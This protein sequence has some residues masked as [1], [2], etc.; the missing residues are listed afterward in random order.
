M[1]P[2]AGKKLKRVAKAS[3]LSGYLGNILG[4]STLVL[5]LPLGYAMRNVW[6]P[7]KPGQPNIIYILA[8]DL[9]YGD[10]SCYQPEGKIHTPH[11][12]RLADQGIRFT[13][14]HSPSGVC[15]PTRYGILTGEYPWRSRLP[16]GVLRGYSRNL[17][18]PGKGTVAELLRSHGYQTAVVGKW[19]LGLDWVIRAEA[20]PTV[21]ALS[22]DYGI[23]T[24]MDSADIDFLS[25]PTMG[26]RELGFVY[27]YILPAS[28][29]MPPYGYLEN[30]RWESLPTS[31]TPGNKLESGYTG[32]F[33]RAGKM[34]PDFDFLQVLPQFV[35]KAK[36]FLDK[37]TP[38]KP[39]F[40]F[41]PLAAPHTPWVPTSPFTG[42][43]QAGEYGD[44]VQQVDHAVGEILELLEK[45]KL[46]SQTLVLFTSDNGPYWREPLI[47][48]FGHRSA[49]PFRGMKGDAWE[50]GHRVP[51][52]ARW[53]GKIRKG[54]ISQ[55]PVCQTSFMATLRALLRD[56]NP[57]FYRSD[58]QSLLP[59]LLGKASGKF[60]PPPI[61]HS[62][63][64][65]YFAIRHGSW[66]MIAGLGSGGFS[67]PNREMPH[68]GG[69]DVQLYNL[70]SDPGEKENLAL[71]H[72][73]IVR[74]LKQKLAEIKLN[75]H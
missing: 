61:I 74:D 55:I 54:S 35:A 38:E 28:L 7:E 4:L 57:R 53:P 15:T 24:E 59:A 19:H 41:L 20:R 26:P 25:P 43:S 13:D 14:M 68:P 48:Q 65:G 72:P 8:D 69:P 31:F 9:G 46:A 36:A 49:G 56:T 2:F 33:W 58:S 12:D 67:E 52:I 3:S 29:D 47:S 73:T 10:L 75:Q 64:R 11:I 50:G 42:S 44:F 32:P 40:L 62:S 39:F 71:R 18:E 34:A 6:R 63:S 51:F 37:Q 16:V 27:S 23:Q 45:K 1:I 5:G 17:I 30:Q 21:Q 60:P 22:R 70:A 66:K